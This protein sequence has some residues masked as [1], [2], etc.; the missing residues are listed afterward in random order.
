MSAGQAPVFTAIGRYYDDLVARYG[1][2]PR[3]CDYGRAE[4]Q[5]IKFAVLSQVAPLDGKRILDVGCGFAD[6]ATY[7]SAHFRDVGYTGVDLSAAMVASAHALH[8]DLAIRA[9]NILD[10]DVGSF[11]IVTANGIFYLLGAE[12][13]DL[14]HAL[15]ARMYASATEAVAFNS[16]SAWA[17]DQEAGEYY[18][19]PSA[20]LDYCRTLT[21][22]VVLRH[23]YHSR[24]FTVY[25]Y[26][27]R[28]P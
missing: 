7:L 8:P 6:Y 17:T 27:T 4:S 18:A 5:A 12:A 15:I 19:D 25:L 9:A 2:D 16:L 10:E 13:P 11:D 14:M 28:R 20:V 3:A 26:R 24:D 23:D 1:H 21:P 22:W